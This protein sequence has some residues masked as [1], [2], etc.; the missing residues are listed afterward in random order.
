M[1]VALSVKV[2]SD[3]EQ[4]RETF[5]T[6]TQ[7]RDLARQEKNQLRGQLENLEEVLKVRNTIH[8]HLFCQL[9]LTDLNANTHKATIIII[10]SSVL[11]HL[12]LNMYNRLILIC[13]ITF[14]LHQPSSDVSFEVMR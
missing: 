8:P 13:L 11:L 4:L 9:K 6:V 3:Y 2:K 1:A 12:T 10:I 5:G 7:E 14:C